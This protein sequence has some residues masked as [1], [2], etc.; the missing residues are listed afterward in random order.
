MLWVREVYREDQKHLRSQNPGSNHERTGET[1]VAI[2]L[3]PHNSLLFPDGWKWDV[4]HHIPF[5]LLYRMKFYNNKS[6]PSLELSLEGP[7]KSL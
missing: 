3:V 1:Q 4:F 6:Y 7:E 5:H 2:T